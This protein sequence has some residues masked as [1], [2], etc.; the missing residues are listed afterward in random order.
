MANKEQDLHLKYRPTSLRDLVGQ[1][2]AVAQLKGMRDNIPH[3]ILFT[4]PSGCGKTTIARIIRHR[5]QCGDHDFEEINAAETRGIEMVRGLKAR[6][7][8][9]PVGG[10]T[11]VYL[12]DECHQL[13]ADAQGALLKLLEEPPQHVYFMLATT[14]P[15][16][17][18]QA[19]RTRCTDIK[20]RALDEDELVALAKRVAEAEGY[21]LEDEVY[22]KL[23]EVA[24]GSARKALVLLGQVANIKGGAAAQVDALEKTDTAVAAYAL[25]QALLYRKPWPKVAEI[26]RAL[27]DDPEGVRRLI[28]ACLQTVAIGK[29][30]AK[31][32]KV[33]QPGK[34]AGRAVAIME[35]FQDN[36][37]DTGKAGLVM[38]CHR[39]SN[40]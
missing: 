16:K 4:G 23:A 40:L 3:A 18:R 38:S 7:G 34:D 26:L 9:A 12:V 13:T 33:R 25:F 39:A 8:L 11:R 5:L 1:P 19:I 29:V 17:L 21:G 2:Q 22:A 15:G 24:Q 31:T 6:M 27:D 14:H 36:Y 35:E 28:L 30:D 32:G 37:F 20:V 10:R